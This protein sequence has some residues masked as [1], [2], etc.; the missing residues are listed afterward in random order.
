MT[1]ANE[2][3]PHGYGAFRGRSIP[4]TYNEEHRRRELDSDSTG[5]VDGPRPET[6]LTDA[7]IAASVPTYALIVK[8]GTGR[9]S[10]RLYLS[11]PAAIKATARAQHRGH[12]ASLELVRLV[13]YVTGADLH[14]EV[15]PGE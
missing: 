4:T 10:R 13:P 11:L 3:A 5:N 1:I 15:V 7:E 8:S 2:N 14:G 12:A 9:I 6:G